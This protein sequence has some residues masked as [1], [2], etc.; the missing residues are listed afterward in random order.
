MHISLLT[1]CSWCVFVTGFGIVSALA[2]ELWM[3]R[4]M[5]RITYSLVMLSLLMLI[6]CALLVS[7]CPVPRQTASEIR[8]WQSMY[9][10]AA[11][12]A[13]DTTQTRDR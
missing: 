13:R 6:V 11:Q 4:E 2:L 5:D 8:A 12:M 1:V 10:H 7:C 9:A 3:L